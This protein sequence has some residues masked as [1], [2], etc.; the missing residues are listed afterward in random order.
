MASDFLDP[1]QLIPTL[2]IVVG[3]MVGLVGIWNS[4]KARQRETKQDIETSIVSSENRLKEFFEVRFKVVDAQT[5]GINQ[6]IDRQMGDIKEQIK[7]HSERVSK[8][9]TERESF[10]K[11]WIQRVEDEIDTNRHSGRTQRR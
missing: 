2:G 9:L 3:M 11:D 5:T 1:L 4:I 8:Q 6:R 10:F 7:D